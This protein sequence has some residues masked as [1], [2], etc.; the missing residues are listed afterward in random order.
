MCHIFPI[1]I[2]TDISHSNFSFFFFAEWGSYIIYSFK[3]YCLLLNYE[4]VP[5]SLNVLITIS[6]Y[7]HSIILVL[8]IKKIKKWNNTVY[9]FLCLA[10]EFK[11]TLLKLI[12]VVCVA[13]VCSFSLINT[14]PLYEATISYISI[15]L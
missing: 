6:L 1:E 14:I 7:S 12:H 9:I 11:F 2:L 8:S 3:C 15:S 13:I 4:H 10:F 5:I